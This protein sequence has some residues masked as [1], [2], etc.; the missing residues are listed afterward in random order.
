M[1]LASVVMG[2]TAACGGEASVSMYTT[3]DGERPGGS[4]SLRKGDGKQRFG[5][6]NPDRAN[7][8]YQLAKQREEH[9][10]KRFCVREVAAALQPLL[11]RP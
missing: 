4:P 11:F 3:Y 2:R 5:G 8:C 9:P 10:D 6:K 7:T 1:P